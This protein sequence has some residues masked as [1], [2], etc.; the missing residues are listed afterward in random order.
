[1][2]LRTILCF[3]FLLAGVLLLHVGVSALQQP[4]RPKT[5]SS[6]SRSRGAA[7]NSLS[8]TTAATATLMETASATMSIS[9]VADTYSLPVPPPAFE[10]PLWK[11]ALAGSLATMVSDMSMHP[12]D[13]I[14]TLQQSDQGM[15]L[16][17]GQAAQVVYAQL[18]LAGFYKGF[19]TYALC[20]SV[21]GALKFSS[22][23]I[24]KRQVQP[25]LQQGA[26][27]NAVLFGCA[28]VAFVASSVITVPGELL[29]QQLQMAHYSG[30]WEAITSI[31]QAQ[32][33]GG[34]YQGYEGVFLRDV[35]YTAM[36]LGLYEMMKNTFSSIQ[37][38]QQQKEN[39][40]NASSPAS[41]SLGPSVEI[42]AAGLTGAIAGYLTTPLDTIKTKMMVDSDYMG[43]SFWDT[44]M[45]TVHDHGMGSIWVGSLA[46]V[47]WLLPATAI[48]LPTY[49]FLKR[50]FTK[51]EQAEDVDK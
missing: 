10:L 23:E 12:M 29:K 20:D 32:G 31:W 42:L 28:A 3:R 47:A 18:G 17:V 43:C 24:L 9:T 33:I 39:G 21:G 37:Q 2:T 25:K 4:Q 11:L 30:L 49:D 16:D 8:S 41:T 45:L 5:T 19:G 48:Y 7:S 38:Q 13:C 15:G 44:L 26:S 34:F 22:F 6:M 51:N 40:D 35:P 36:E 50:E 14:K 27:K 1:M 46:R